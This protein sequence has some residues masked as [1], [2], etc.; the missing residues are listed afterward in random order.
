MVKYKIQNYPPY[1]KKVEC[2]KETDCMVLVDMGPGQKPFERRKD[3]EY[4]DTFSDAKLALM[5]SIVDKIDYLSDRIA[6]QHEELA[7]IERLEE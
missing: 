4:F 7:K 5:Q 2:V 6:Y 3:G 1:I